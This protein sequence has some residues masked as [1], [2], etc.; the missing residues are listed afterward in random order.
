MEYWNNPLIQI[1][2]PAGDRDPIKDSLHGGAHAIFYDPRASYASVQ[3]NQRLQD[4]CDWA[5]ERLEFN[6]PDAFVAD[7]KNHY[8]I[9]N[10]VKLNLWIQDIQRQGIVKPWLMQDQG[11]GT[12]LAGTG[13]SRMRCLERLPHITTVPAFICTTYQRRDLYRHLQPVTDFDAFARLCDA[14]PGQM[15]LFRLTEPGAPYGLYWY[16]Y[17]SERTRLVTPGESQSVTMFG[18]YLKRHPGIMI[19]PGWFDTP[20][21]WDDYAG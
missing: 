6:G 7:A 4:L 21:D 5:N 16:E 17:N 11:D 13:D 12:F 8:D 18:N 15:F 19:T 20:V 1:T 2:W 14:V 9:A 10:L 3:T